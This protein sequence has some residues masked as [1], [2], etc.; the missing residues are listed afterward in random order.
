M[1][2]FPGAIVGIENTGNVFSSLSLHDGLVVHALVELLE[3]ELVAR[4]GAPKSQS[5]GVIGIETWNRGIISL[6]K[7]NF[8]AL[9]VGIPSSV[10]LFRDLSTKSHRVVNVGTFNLPRVSSGEPVVRH[11]K[12]IPIL[13]FLSENTVIVSNTVTHGRN[14]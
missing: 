8:T 12:L 11:L 4:F 14:I 13:N 10:A 3:I 9:P 2:A 5:I 6:G 7:N 1:L